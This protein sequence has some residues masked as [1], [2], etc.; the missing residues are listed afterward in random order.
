MAEI[1]SASSETNERIV[2]VSAEQL[3]PNSEDKALH[4]ATTSGLTMATKY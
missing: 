4:I 3:T 1:L 2:L